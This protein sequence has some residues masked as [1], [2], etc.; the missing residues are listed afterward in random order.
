VQFKGKNIRHYE[1]Y[2]R[3]RVGKTLLD[4]LSEFDAEGKLFNTHKFAYYNDVRKDQVL[5][6]FTADQ[7]VG[8]FPRGK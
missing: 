2:Y 6:P 5:V 4:S 7:R 8:R 3:R 1:L